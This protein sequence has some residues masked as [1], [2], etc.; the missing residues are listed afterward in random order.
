MIFGKASTCCYAIRRTTAHTF[1]WNGDVYV[2]D[3][4]VC[5]EWRV[6]NLVERPLVEILR[7]AILEDFAQLRLELPS[8]CRQ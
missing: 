4:F 1:E 6:G 8:R 7:D 5:K 3:H 2:C